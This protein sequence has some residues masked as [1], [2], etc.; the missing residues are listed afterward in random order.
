MA[1]LLYLFNS[2]LGHPTPSNLERAHIF[3]KKLRQNLMY[4][5]PQQK[6]SAMKARL[7]CSS[8]QNQISIGRWQHLEPGRSSRVTRFLLAAVEQREMPPVQTNRHQLFHKTQHPHKTTPKHQPRNSVV[9]LPV[10]TTAHQVHNSRIVKCE[11]AHV[12]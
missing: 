9:V 8:L 2:W 5:H 7:R 12:N 1:K 4:M 11:T 3:Q 6:S 10:P